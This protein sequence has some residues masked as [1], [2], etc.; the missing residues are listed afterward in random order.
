MGRLSL[1][2]MLNMGPGSGLGLG[3]GIALPPTHHL[4]YPGYTPPRPTARVHLGARVSGPEYGRGA[5][6]RRP[7]HLSGAFLRLKDYYRGL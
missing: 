6:I 3:T 1:K 7:T 2:N 4:P 5:H